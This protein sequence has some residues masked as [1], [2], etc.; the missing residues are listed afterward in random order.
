MEI[1]WYGH[2]SFLI[3]TEQGIKIITDPYEPGYAGLSYGPIPDEADIVTVSHDHGDHNYIVGV[4]GTPQVVKGAGRHE[5]KG[6]VFEGIATY[7]D[8]SRGSQ[9]GD[10]T[11]FTFVTDGIRMCHAGDLGHI[12]PA[13]DV[14]KIG[15]VDILFIPV[16][17]FYTIDHEAA[18]EVV[19][20]LK[21]RVVIPMH[22]KNDK[23]DFPI[24]PVDTF[25]RGKGGVTR[26]DNSSYSI[27]KVTLAEAPNIVV[28]KPAL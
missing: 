13:Q 15:S 28:L 19:G 26:R 4:P 25:L 11:I 17:G 8:E 24:D 6:I 23:C 7:H 5:A 21:P 18:T 9:R 16:G 2:A 27:T 12:L 22:V 20:Q 14:E 3:A 10:N 1:T